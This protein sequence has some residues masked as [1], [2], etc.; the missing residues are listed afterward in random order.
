MNQTISSLISDK[1]SSINFNAIPEQVRERAKYLIMDAL[2]IAY[3]STQ[4]DFAEK[5]LA[6]ILAISEPTPNGVPVIGMNVS[7]P[8]RDAAIVNGLLIHGLD[9]DD[10]HP[11]GV[12]HATAPVLAAVLS[13]SHRLQKSGEDLLTAYIVGIEVATRLGAAAKGSFHQVGFHPTGLIGAFGAT[14]AAAWLDKL[15]AGQM[16]HAQG[17]TLSLASGS[18]EFLQD[19]A[20]TKR[21]HPGWA[22]NA[23]ITSA[24]LAKH[25][26]LGP[27]E[28]YE[29]RFGLYASHLGADFKLEGLEESISTIG[30]EWELMNIAVKPI[31]ACHFT[32]ACTDAAAIIAKQFNLEDILKIEAKVPAGVMKTV[33][34]P[35]E[36]K[37]KPA[38]SYEAQFSIPYSVATGLRFGRFSLD[39]LDEKAYTDPETLALAAKVISVP[40]PDA[41]FPR[42]YSGEVVVTLNDGKVISHREAINRGADVRP[43]TNGEVEAKYVENTGNLLDAGKIAQISSALKGLENQSA[44]QLMNLLSTK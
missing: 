42:Y 43:I 10:T 14:L 36:N 22:A 3:A 44:S 20:W 34:E 31:P 18:L 11:K 41:D 5:T 25:G 30:Q 1:I 37:Q 6:G 8:A 23:A 33:C 17:I 4:Y 32:H 28:T 35:A 21:I 9:Y 26:F 16:T 15:D 29:G 13:Q 39:A 7:L 2:G 27:R 19:G 12:I 40:D 24:S 38:N